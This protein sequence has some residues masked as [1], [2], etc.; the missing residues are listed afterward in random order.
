MVEV[1]F[2][3][4]HKKIIDEISKAKQTIKIAVAWF[5]D[6]QIYNELVRVSK[7]VA[8]DVIVANHRINK[9]SK[10][11][12]KA[13]LKSGGRVKYIGE[14]KDDKK[15]KLMHNKFCIIDNATVLTGSY[16]WTFKARTNDENILLIK[17]ENKVI[18]NFTEKFENLNPQYGFGLKD[19]QVSVFPIEEIMK[20]WEKQKVSVNK[21]RNNKSSN[22]NSILD[23]F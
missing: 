3:D 15:D 9:E 6:Y 2:N 14:D 21:I 17:N 18:Q 23:K 7:K 10:V 8:V 22:K 13:L 5:T 4:I 1:Y 16:N 19:N 12:F 11:D 20:K